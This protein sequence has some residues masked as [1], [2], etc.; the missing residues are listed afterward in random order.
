LTIVNMSAGVCPTMT[1]ENIL[2]IVINN[3][4]SNKKLLE[5]RSSN[6]L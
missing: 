6:F 3:S 1:V 4:N 5:Y 2:I